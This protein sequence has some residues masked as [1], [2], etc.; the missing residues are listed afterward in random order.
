MQGELLNEPTLVEIAKEYNKSTAQIIIRQDIQ[1]GVVTIPKSVK[2][3]R[4]AENADV[5]DFEISPENM[6]KINAL[7]KDQRMFANLDDF[8][9]VQVSHLKFIQ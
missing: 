6:D 9:R 8:D 5:L 1:T 3:H 4:I 7:N 2:A